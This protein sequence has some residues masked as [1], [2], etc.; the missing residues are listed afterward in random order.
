MTVRIY[1]AARL[2]RTLRQ[3]GATVADLKA[4]HKAAAEI[5]G[6]AAAARAPRRS[7]RLARTVRNSA[8]QTAGII[9][10]GRKSV[11]YAGV[12][13]WGWPRRNIRANPWITEAAR[14]TEPRWVDAFMQHT[15]QAIERVRGI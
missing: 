12:I 14:A 10:A 8:T 9:R 1:G 11:P 15:E 5:A 13:H 7:G 2:R 4:P 3:A 6:R